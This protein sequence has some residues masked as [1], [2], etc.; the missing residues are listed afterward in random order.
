MK[1][2]TV[3]YHGD[4]MTFLVPHPPLAQGGEMNFPCFFHHTQAPSNTSKPKS[5]VARF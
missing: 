1:I 3:G 2:R 4:G 5:Q